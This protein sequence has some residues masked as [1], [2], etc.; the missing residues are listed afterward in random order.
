MTHTQESFLALFGYFFYLLIIP[1]ILLIALIVWIAWRF[2][3][4]RIPF[5]T[6]LAIALCWNFV[7]P[8]IRSDNALYL[9]LSEILDERARLWTLPRSEGGTREYDISHLVCPLVSNQLL[10]EMYQDSI[11][12]TT[13]PRV[14]YQHTNSP[15]WGPPNERDSWDLV[16]RKMFHSEVLWIQLA[17]PD[18]CYAR[19]Q[20]DF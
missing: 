11:S 18:Y 12:A 9:R 7:F 10:T 8:P 15:A 1:T 19:F 13:G 3:K 20:R 2:P 17:E 6:V 16:R 14:S 5:A 4:V